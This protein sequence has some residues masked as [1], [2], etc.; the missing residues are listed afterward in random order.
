MRSCC[1]AMITKFA[2]Q[3]DIQNFLKSR[4]HVNIDSSLSVTS[5]I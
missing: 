1:S 5:A 3:V 2:T 4:G